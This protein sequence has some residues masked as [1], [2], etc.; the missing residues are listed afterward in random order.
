MSP[1][2]GIFKEIKKAD[3]AKKFSRLKQRFKN[4]HNNMEY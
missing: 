2:M 4:W 3:T 1:S